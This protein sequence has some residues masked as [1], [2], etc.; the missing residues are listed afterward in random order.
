MY[1]PFHD[2]LFEQGIQ[3]KDQ[4]SNE[5]IVDILEEYK[6]NNG[7]DLDQEEWFANIKEMAVSRRFAARGKDFKKHPEEYIGTVGDYAEILRLATCAK[8]NTPNFYSV[9]TILGENEVKRRIDKTINFL[10]Q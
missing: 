10:N 8:N 5:L 7:L 3:F 9:L 1:E 6:K 4:F 2:K